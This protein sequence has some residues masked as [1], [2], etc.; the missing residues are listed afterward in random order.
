VGFFMGADEKSAERNRQKTKGLDP[1]LVEGTLV[2]TAQE[3]TDR[4]QEYVRAGAQG[5]NLSIRPPVDWDALEAF[6]E[7]VMPPFQK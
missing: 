5:I 2:G 4:M 7:R 3:V 1:S 6:I